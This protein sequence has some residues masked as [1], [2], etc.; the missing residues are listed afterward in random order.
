[1][2]YWA[3]LQ[4]CLYSTVAAG[5][6]ETSNPADGGGCLERRCFFVAGDT[7]SNSVMGIAA[8]LLAT[9]IVD[10]S[11]NMPVA[12]LAGMLAG[13]GIAIILMPIFVASFGAMEV[14][15]PTMLTA[16][17]AGMV[18][19]MVGSMHALTAREAAIG[20]GLI[21]ILTLLL[22][23]TADARMRSRNQ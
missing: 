12:M 18:F 3:F 8:A 4:V 7:L 13:M 1:V 9:Y 23:Y 20:G 21:G 22:T 14:M 17:L 11:W 15:L 16:M 2:Y 5:T 6:Q 19:G 10:T